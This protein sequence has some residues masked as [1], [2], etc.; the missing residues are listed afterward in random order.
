MT[1]NKTLQAT[2]WMQETCDRFPT[3]FVYQSCDTST[4][5]YLQP[6]IHTPTHAAQVISLIKH[7]NHLNCHEEIVH[8]AHSDMHINLNIKRKEKLLIR[9]MSLTFRLTDIDAILLSTTYCT[10]L[11]RNNCPVLY[12]RQPMIPV[13]W[14]GRKITYFVSFMKQVE[15]H[16][17]EESLCCCCFCVSPAF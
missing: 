12:Q 10:S 3:D 13:T 15:D 5:A 4:V 2:T 6:N 7:N 11:E 16:I 17:C 14:I 8:Y 1:F 9:D